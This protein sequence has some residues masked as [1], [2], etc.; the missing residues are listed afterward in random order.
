M[1][2]RLEKTPKKSDDE[3]QV[4]HTWKWSEGACVPLEVKWSDEGG[5]M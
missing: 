3:L 1:A 2:Q 4:R 5:R